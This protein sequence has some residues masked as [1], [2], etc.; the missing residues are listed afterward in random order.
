MIP[1]QI[2]F[3]A[4]FKAGAKSFDESVNLWPEGEKG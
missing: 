1:Y 4:R 2:K 3:N